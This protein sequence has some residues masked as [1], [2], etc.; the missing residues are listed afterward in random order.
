MFAMLAALPLAIAATA[1]GVI[2]TCIAAGVTLAAMALQYFLVRYGT[3][4][5]GLVLPIIAL[6]LCTLS[7]L[8]GLLMVYWQSRDIFDA[9]SYLPGLLSGNIPAALLFLERHR[10][11]KHMRKKEEAA[12]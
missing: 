5:A 8:A 7:A 2:Y 4:R 10:I 3:R 12:Q 11:L 9:L 1:F 6:C